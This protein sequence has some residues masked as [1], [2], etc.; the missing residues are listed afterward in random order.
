MAQEYVEFSLPPGFSL[1]ETSSGPGQEFDLVCTF[2]PKDGGKVCLVKFGEIQM[3]DK[4]EK[5]KAPDYKE[6][7]QGIVQDM[8]MIRRGPDESE[9]D[10]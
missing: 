7:S 10:Y 9:D 1:P 3:P 2:R 6:M 8:G 5:E 4:E